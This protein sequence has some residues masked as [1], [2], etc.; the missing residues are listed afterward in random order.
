[1]DRRKFISTTAAASF[2]APAFLNAQAKAGK[3]YKTALIGSGWWGMNILREAIAAKTCG[4]IS[5]CDVDA[6]A[7]E[8]SAD[9]VND[10]TGALPKTYKDYR[11]LLEKEKPEIVII[12]TPDHWHALPAIAALEAGAHLF[13]EKPTGHTIM[14]SRAILNTAKTADRVLQMGMH[15]RIGPH[16]VSGMKFLKDGGAGNIGMVRMFVAGGGGAESP[17][18]NAKVPGGL[19]SSSSWLESHAG[20]GWRNRTSR[21]FSGCMVR[22]K[23]PRRTCF[24]L[25][26]GLLAP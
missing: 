10:L 16:H 9:E 22:P 5:L 3:K 20:F 1:M 26:L 17:S 25:L 6:D 11:E 21:L 7:L 15:R 8:V 2:A 18:P 13:L 23:R 14:E 4:A 19:E 12:A 24:H